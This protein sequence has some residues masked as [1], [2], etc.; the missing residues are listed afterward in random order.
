MI[1]RKEDKTKGVTMPDDRIEP[2][3]K[4]MKDLSNKLEELEKTLN[5]QKI[6]LETILLTVKDRLE[7]KWLQ[8]TGPN[9]FSGYD[10][11]AQDLREKGFYIRKTFK[12]GSLEL[13]LKN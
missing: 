12:E 8:N 11:K 1:L 2:L 10:Q 3:Q 9:W 13:W 4:E 7:Y 6:E 5:Y